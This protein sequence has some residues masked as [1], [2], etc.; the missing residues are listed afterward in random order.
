MRFN[1]QR[2]DATFWGV[3]I[4]GSLLAGTFGCFGLA[5]AAQTSSTEATGIISVSDTLR[6]MEQPRTTI[7]MGVMTE[8]LHNG[9]IASESVVL[10]DAV[11]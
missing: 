6:Q 8:R 7:R 2:F 3:I 4:L 10:A 5:V 1:G 9:G 11:R